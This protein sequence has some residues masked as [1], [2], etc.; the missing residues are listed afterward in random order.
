M[1]LATGTT[2]ITATY[3]GMTTTQTL[4]TFDASTATSLNL[5]GPATLTASVSHSSQLVAA[6][7]FPNVPSQN[8]SN[9][10]TWQSSTAVATVSSAGLVTAVAAG[11]TTITA[12]YFQASGTL[13]IP[14]N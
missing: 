13:S 10:A 4:A 2:T 9:A 3:M 7:T 8:V 14:V 12:T 5:F 6:A 11:T 1:A